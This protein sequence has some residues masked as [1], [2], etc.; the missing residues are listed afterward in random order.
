MPH[1]YNLVARKLTS[2]FSKDVLTII[3]LLY[4]Y[5]NKSKKKWDSFLS[6]AQ[7]RSKTVTRFKKHY[8]SRWTSLIDSLEAVINNWTIL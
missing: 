6:L 2:F 7:S 8:P 1:C 5:F 4:K 3:S